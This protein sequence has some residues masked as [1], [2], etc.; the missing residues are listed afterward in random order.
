[1]VL[2][3]C[4][5][6]WLGAIAVNIWLTPPV[7]MATARPQARAET[8]EKAPLADYQIVLERNIFDSSGASAGFLDGTTA[9]AAEV[10]PA[11]TEESP[12]PAPRKDLTLI[13][14]VVAGD[15]SLA[16]IREG[17]QTEIHGIGDEVGGARVD[18]IDRNSVTLKNQDG[19]LEV[20]TIPSE[21]GVAVK[22]ASRAANGAPQTAAAGRYNIQ[23][24]G[25]NKWLIP[26]QTADEARS[27]LN[28]LLQ[29]ARMEPRIVGG[30][31]QGFIVRMI[32]PNSFLDMLGLRRGDILMEIN[33]VDLNSPEK[34]LQIFQQLREARNISVSLVRNG[35]RMTFDYEIN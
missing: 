3:G 19:S 34:A 7:E 13:G 35:Q 11:R 31:T 14:T 25:E 29:Q 1:M 26:R 12:A 23:P 32:R 27:N 17:A 21:G 6:G 10:T 30:Q 33:N 28:E 18:R 16:V 5:V 9:D 20:L 22:S 15:A 4:V 24:V 8:A 2:L